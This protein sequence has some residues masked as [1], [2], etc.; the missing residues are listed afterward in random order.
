MGN[1]LVTNF[2]NHIIPLRMS[3]RLV[4]FI[5][6]HCKYTGRRECSVDDVSASVPPAY[7]RKIPAALTSG[8][9]KNN[10]WSK[11]SRNVSK[12]HKKAVTRLLDYR[13]QKLFTYHYND[14]TFGECLPER[15]IRK[16]NKL[17]CPFLISDGNRYSPYI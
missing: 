4:L 9:D 5:F 16:Q 10:D 15:Q 2:L 14:L 12:R 13:F 6:K 11:M 7:L 17:L 8:G 3:L 1:Q